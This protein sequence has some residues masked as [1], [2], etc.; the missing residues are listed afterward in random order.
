TLAVSPSRCSDRSSAGSRRAVEARKEE[1]GM[2]KPEEFGLSSARLDRIGD[3][4]QRYID[5]GKL[6]GTLM[7]VAGLGRIA[8]LEPRGH[9][10]IEKRRPVA[11]DSIFRIYSMTKPIVSVGLMM[12]W[13]QGRFQLD[14]PVSKFIPSWKDHRVFVGGNHPN[15]KTA[16]VER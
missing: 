1:D 8:Y 6:A 7:L 13:E 12:L 3:H 11:P 15:W 5:A 14:D 4:L 9:L 16:P 2:V 10:E